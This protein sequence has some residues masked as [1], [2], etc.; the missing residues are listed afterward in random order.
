M[1]FLTTPA[2][3]RVLFAALYASEGAP[4]GFLW[5]ALPT[6]LRA[7]GVPVEA[8]AAI[9]AA[10]ALPWA[11]KVL[12]APVIDAVA[13][14]RFGPRPVIVVCQLAMGL[15]L[16]PL[17]GADLNRDWE[18]VRVLLL[19]HACFAAT[20]DVAVD[21]LAVRNV[22]EQE[23]GALNGF[24]QAGMLAARSLFGGGVLIVERTVGLSGVIVALVVVIWSS[25][26]LVLLSPEPAV[27]RDAV[28]A[29]HATTRARL[30]ELGGAL[31]AAA[32]ERVTWLALAFALLSGAGFEAVGALAGPMLLD[33]GARQETVGAF[34]FLPAA[35]AMTL[36][37]LF[38]GWLS[39][40]GDRRRACA[41]SLLAMV[42]GVLAVALA[43]RAGTPV[44]LT[45]LTLLYLTIGAFTATSY[46]LFMDLTHPRI[47]ATQFSAYMGA[48]NACESWSAFSAGKLTARFGYGVAFALL[49]AASLLALPLLRAMR[50]APSR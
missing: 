6:R 7:S 21:A 48:T 26:L 10:L 9:S 34:L 33:G 45:A 46:A 8:V 50:R 41:F 20:Q 30:R 5:W 4:I 15:C 11:L 43:S 12:W 17:V 37:A 39:D 36:G 25:L 35:G 2:R 40:R 47:A 13:L 32:R 16:L 22:A 23:R 44:A 24:M 18:W 27:V 28:G 3:R 31:A 14:G 29:T 49:A 19:A 38:G 1:S 42:T